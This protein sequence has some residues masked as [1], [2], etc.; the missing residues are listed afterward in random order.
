MAARVENHLTLPGE[1]KEAA[2]Q[3]M[4]EALAAFTA[5]ALERKLLAGA[6]HASPGHESRKD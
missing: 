5:Q 1:E 4:F 3:G 6:G 2:A